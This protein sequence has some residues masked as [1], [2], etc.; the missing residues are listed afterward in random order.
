MKNDMLN[1]M[2]GLVTGDALGSPVQFMSK[3]AI[4][5][6]GRIEEMEP[7]PGFGMPA[8]AWTDDSSMA[9][10]A[11]ASQKEKG[12]IDLQDIM[13]RLEGWL[14]HNEYT[15]CGVT[16]D[17][18]YTCATAIQNFTRGK[19]P[20]KCGL[21]GEYA[22]GNGA[23]MRIL[24]TCI[25]CARLERQGTLTEAEAVAAV[26][27]VAALTHNHHRT[28]MACGLYYF[29]TRKLMETEG[30]LPQLLREALNEGFAFYD[31]R[32]GDREP[33]LNPLRDLDTLA[34]RPENSI[35]DS[36]YVVHTLLAAVWGLLNSDS[37][38]SALL[39]VVN[40]GEDTDTV[41]A[42][43][44][45]LAGLYYGKDAI[46]EAWL[47]EVKRLSWIEELCAEN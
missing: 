16:F 18:G 33:E 38:R 41:G 4:R 32:D 39:K 20:E 10:A 13:V 45:G 46:P 11:L 30:E 15:S 23:L 27:S 37:Y 44:G 19:S 9:L 12:R 8:G 26:E 40:L 42:V 14:Y 31:Q 43:C 47:R 29:M 21:T 17:V 6:R 7:C 34:A 25:F 24:P 3:E 1:G 36:G 28:N 2:L 22:N 5:R 35:P